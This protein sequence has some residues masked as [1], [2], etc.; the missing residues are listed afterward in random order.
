MLIDDGSKSRGQR[1]NIFKA[2]FNHISCFTGPHV[3]LKTVSCINYAGAFTAL[4]A[5]DPIQAIMKAFLK[6][7]VEFEMPPNVRTWKQKSKV[8][9][10]G[11]VA[12]KTTYREL[13]MKDGSDDTLVKEE[14][15]E[16]S[17]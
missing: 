2:E 14:T 9:V 1:N 13:K 17:L 10:K 5:E 11:A 8:S 3:D 6:E 7:E 12:T 4:G 16:I 15:K